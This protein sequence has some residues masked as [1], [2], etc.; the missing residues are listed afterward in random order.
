MYSV[1]KG[2]KQVRNI[3]Q[4]HLENKDSERSCITGGLGFTQDL[5]RT[6]LP[7]VGLYFLTLRH[8]VQVQVSFNG[9]A[10]TQQPGG[11]VVLGRTVFDYSCNPAMLLCPWDFT[12]RIQ[13]FGALCRIFQGLDLSLA[14]YYASPWAG[15]PSRAALGSPVVEKE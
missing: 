4:A 15:S 10:V 9:H 5:R 1:P 7:S 3:S 6:R 13:K 2:W 12:G 8:D 11:E 14:E